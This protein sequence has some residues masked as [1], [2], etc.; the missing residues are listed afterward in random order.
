MSTPLLR[1]D[2]REEL[3]GLQKRFEGPPWV[4]MCRQDELDYISSLEVTIR[5]LLEIL[6][7]AKEL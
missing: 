6:L 3:R 1:E 4:S 5:R 7:E 2:T